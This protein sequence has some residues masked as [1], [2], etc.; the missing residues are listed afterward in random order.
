MSTEN[1]HWV[2][3]DFGTSNTAAAIE[4][5]GSP[6]IV[7]YGNYQYFPTVACVLDDGSIE[8]CQNA[9]GFR[10][11]H[12]ETF[13]QEFKLNIGDDIDINTA[14]YTDIVAKILEFIKGCAETENNSHQIENVLLT[15]PAL[16]T[17][18]DHRKAVMLAA[19][20]K[21]GFANVEFIKEPDAAAHHYA[22]ITKQKAIGLTLIY[23]LG[24]GTFDPAL[25]DLSMKSTVLL[26]SDTG[27]KCGGH[28]FDRA[29][30]KH[31]SSHFKDTAPLSK[32]SR[33]E[34]YEAC[35]RLKESLSALQSA[36][37]MFSNGEKYTLSR[38]E[39]NELLKPLI[40]ETLKS[41]DN[42]VAS[43]NR[44]WADVKQVIL[45]GGSTAMPLVSEMLERHLISHNASGVKII[46]N[47]KGANGEYN[48]R[49]ATCLGG[50]SLKL[51]PPPPP[52]EKVGT[53]VC[54]GQ[55]YQLR[56]GNNK[57]G[58]S[59]EMDFSFLDPRMS[60]HHFD[61][62]VERIGGGRLKYTVTTQSS[63]QSTIINNMEALNLSLAPIARTSVELFD[64][65]TILAGKTQ[66]RL[67]KISMGDSNT[68]K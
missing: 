48:H 23:D 64:G 20:K 38:A 63:S 10:S 67:K 62:N 27:V 43:S 32:H 9:A 47:T 42:L 14:T 21:A 51:T 37:Q 39:L 34:D 58:R 65:H 50:L 15:I 28:Y 16:Y 29:I 26:G 5:D 7:S 53:L 31:I 52:L 3:I 44:D 4:I 25:V 68:D 41:C 60:R 49:F 24:G 19:A 57:F 55:E 12:P 1:S 22:H 13:K 11:S 59:N 66:F 61:V 54:D 30:Y 46:R 36:S 40:E 33:L 45:V 18:N 17:E 6:H 2:C 56:L 8:V 35:C